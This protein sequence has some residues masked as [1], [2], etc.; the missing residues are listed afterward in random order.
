MFAY[1]VDIHLSPLCT[2]IVSLPDHSADARSVA[3]G[4]VNTYEAPTRKKNMVSELV[5]FFLVF[6]LI[7]TKLLLQ[8]FDYI[9]IYSLITHF[10]KCTVHS[11]RIGGGGVSMSAVNSSNTLDTCTSEASNGKVGGVLLNSTALTFD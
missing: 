7:Y 4:Q 5:V 11:E 2:W 9:S 3:T 10:S 6:F 1:S 8:Y